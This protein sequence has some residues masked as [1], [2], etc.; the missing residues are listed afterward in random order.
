MLDFVLE[1]S[2]QVG[3]LFVGSKVVS[4]FTIGLHATDERFENRFFSWTCEITGDT[5]A[6]SR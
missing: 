5:S 3:I 1:D 4:T 6:E 2:S